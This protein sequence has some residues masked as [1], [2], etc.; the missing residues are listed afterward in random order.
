MNNS[1]NEFNN[2]FL[3]GSWGNNYEPRNM[4]QGSIIRF[5]KDQVKG[6]IDYWGS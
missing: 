4:V 3:V 2:K 1:F 6:Q 5:A